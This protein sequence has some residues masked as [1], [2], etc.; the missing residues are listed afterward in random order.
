MGLEHDG[1]LLLGIDE[2]HSRSCISEIFKEDDVYAVAHS[3]MTM[4]KLFIQSFLIFKF[5]QVNV[6]KISQI[7]VCLVLPLQA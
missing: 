2:R 5:F 1:R 6:L 7:Y 3:M 4:N